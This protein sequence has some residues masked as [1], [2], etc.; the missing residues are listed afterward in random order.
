LIS[1][2]KEPVKFF[3][4]TNRHNLYGASAVLN[5]TALEDIATACHVKKLILIPSCVHEMLVLPYRYDDDIEEL[6]SIIKD[7]NEQE[8]NPCERLADRAFIVEILIT[9]SYVPFVAR[10]KMNGSTK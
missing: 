4:I 2:F 8:I 6:S 5:K 9:F 7:I 1:C 3:V 10:R